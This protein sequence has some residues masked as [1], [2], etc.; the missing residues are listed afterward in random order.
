MKASNED[1][2]LMNMLWGGSSF[3]GASDDAEN[4][5]PVKKK[6]RTA[7]TAIPRA[8][9]AQS[10]QDQAAASAASG[11][12]SESQSDG[13][14][15]FTFSM[16]G[17]G[18]KSAAETRELD[19]S[20]TLVLQSNQ[21]KHVSLTKTN[22]LLDKVDSRLNE[23]TKITKSFVEMIRVQG[24][25]CRAETVWQSLKDARS[26]LQAVADF[27]EALQDK[28]AAPETL[29]A[30][31]QVLRDLKISIPLQINNV[32]CQR[33]LVSMFED[34]KFG[35]IVE[36]L[37]PGFAEVRPEGIK[38]VIGES[39]GDEVSLPLV[40]EFQAGCVAYVINQFFLRHVCAPLLVPRKARLL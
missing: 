36:F 17:G 28:E 22:S 1:D 33:T 5:A 15:R 2:E 14:S 26:M 23:S 34:E 18:K 32:I 24:P 8:R 21:L 30:R 31:A 4:S 11:Q 20:E 6:G 39:V 38:S 29:G 16:A 25:G 7:S 3:G 13:G 19:K 27:L 40:K 10:S 9:G 37:D 35:A 12:Q